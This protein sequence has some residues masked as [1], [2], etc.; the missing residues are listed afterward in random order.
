MH[1]VMEAATQEGVVLAADGADGFVCPLF[2]PSVD[3]MMAI[4]RLLEFLAHE[5]AGLCDIVASLPPQFVAVRTVPCAWENKGTVMRLLHERYKGS[6]E[7]QIDGVQVRMGDD[8]VLVLPDP[9]RPLFRIH[10]ESD[11]ASAAEDLAEKYAR[12]VESLL[13]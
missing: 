4:A 1:A 3:G 6:K 5:K 8:W 2:H 10:A 9:D 7:E 13:S 12:I 11:T